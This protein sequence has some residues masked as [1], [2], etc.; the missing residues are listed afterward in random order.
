MKQKYTCK[1]TFEVPWWRKQTTI[2]NVPSLEASRYNLKRS[3][4]Q[5]QILKAKDN[6][7]THNIQ[8][9]ILTTVVYPCPRQKLYLAT[10]YIEH[11]AIGR[12]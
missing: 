8:K 9:E 10:R 11:M 7:K 1:Q 5:V 12:N 3:P 4:G 2:L 6:D